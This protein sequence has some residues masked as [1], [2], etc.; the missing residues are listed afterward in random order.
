[1]VYCIIQDGRLQINDQLLS[2]NDDDLTKKTNSEAM[3]ALRQAMHT[4]GPT[5]G[6]IKLKIERKHGATTSNG[7]TPEPWDSSQST[8]DSNVTGRGSADVTHKLPDVTQHNERKL[9]A[10]TSPAAAVDT[11]GSSPGS[12]IDQM[13]NPVLD[14][15]TGSMSGSKLR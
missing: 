3:T 12:V 7:S 4:E 5:P 9:S 13:R 6:H 15:I 8:S 1:M 11:T 2:V 10:S 14:R